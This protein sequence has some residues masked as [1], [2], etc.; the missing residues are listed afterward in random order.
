MNSGLKT[1]TQNR[2]STKEKELENQL[3][4]EKIRE[5]TE[6]VMKQTITQ[7][8]LLLKKKVQ[9][10]LIGCQGCKCKN[11]KCLK[12]YCEC[13]RNNA[14]CGPECQCHKHG[15][16]FNDDEHEEE[17]RRA[18]EEILKRNIKAFQS[19]VDKDKN[20]HF[21]GCNCKNSMCQKKYCECFERGVPCT[22]KCK[23]YE[24]RNN[25]QACDTHQE[26]SVNDNI[27]SDIKNKITQEGNTVGDSYQ[28]LTD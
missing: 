6:E 25:K 23:C 9:P 11:S 5:K 18:I 3:L 17:R 1:Q 21:K 13:L 7:T 12:L 26:A 10:G 4:L 22:G 14:T 28:K 24:C 16:C 8:K 27:L 19:K 15:D 2:L 20:E